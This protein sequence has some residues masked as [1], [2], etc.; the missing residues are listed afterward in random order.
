MGKDKRDD[1][2]D[3]FI[4]EL[5]ENITKIFASLFGIPIPKQEVWSNEE[6][7]I[8][9]QEKVMK[10]IHEEKDKIY[11][12]FNIPG[13]DPNTIVLKIKD[14]KLFLYARNAREIRDVTELPKKGKKKIEKW[15]YRN[16]VLEVEIVKK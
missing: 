15:D 14:N 7:S 3:E 8:Q 1:K 10:H 12:Y 2:D 5:F 11:I 4:D 9:E 6:I 16:G 13:V